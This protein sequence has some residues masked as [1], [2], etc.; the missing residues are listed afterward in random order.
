[1]TRDGDSMCVVQCEAGWVR[2]VMRDG[3]G[4]GFGVGVG[5]GGGASFLAWFRGGAGPLARRRKFPVLE[6]GRMR[7]SEHGWGLALFCCAAFAVAPVNA[8]AT[9]AAPV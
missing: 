6:W 9:P 7:R 5:V 2:R 1:M 3:F 8:Q 4:F